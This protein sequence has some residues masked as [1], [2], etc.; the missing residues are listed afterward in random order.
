MS[1]VRKSFVSKR[2]SPTTSAISSFSAAGYV[3]FE[4]SDGVRKQ[5]TMTPFSGAAGSSRARERTIDEPPARV[6]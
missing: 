2:Y 6:T 1:S 4:S 3:Y 5:P